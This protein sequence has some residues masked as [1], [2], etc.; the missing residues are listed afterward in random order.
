[1]AG[2]WQA[3]YQ[4]NHSTVGQDANLIFPGQTLHLG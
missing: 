3:L 4:A 1:M 2:G